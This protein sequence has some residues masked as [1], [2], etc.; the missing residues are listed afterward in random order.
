MATERRIIRC[1]VCKARIALRI[2][3]GH[4]ERHPILL[5]CPKC[6]I[7]IPGE[8]EID[9]EAIAFRFRFT[10]G[11]DVVGE[12]IDNAEYYAEVSGEL[13]TEKLRTLPDGKV[14]PFFSPMFKAMA[15]MGDESFERY[16]HLVVGFIHQSREYWPQIKRTNELWN[17]GQHEHCKNELRSLGL[18]EDRYPL[19]NDLEMLKAMKHLNVNFI[20]AILPEGF[21]S[22]D[23]DA[24]SGTIL[25]LCDTQKE[26]LRA[27]ARRLKDN[28]KLRRCRE[29]FVSR[30]DHFIQTFPH[31]VPVFSAAYYKAPEAQVLQEKGLFTG[32]LRT[33]SQY[34]I[35]S[36]ENLIEMADGIVA[37][38]NLIHRNDYN[39]MRPLRKD[40]VALDDYARLQ[41][42]DRLQFIINADE[43]FGDCLGPYINNRVR[44]S[45][46]HGSTRF[47]PITQQLD[48]YS[49]LAQTTPAVSKYLTEFANDCRL[50][51]QGL[52]RLMEVNTWLERISLFDEGQHPSPLRGW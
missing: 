30:V 23:A 22:H 28:G 51:L 44:N 38:N 50:T 8:I 41:K 1:T 15:E 2:L 49:G 52:F 17:N 39:A 25:G 26:Q 40:V 32:S 21:F 35:D 45:I 29:L 10:N 14:P 11:E 9:Q 20:G 46:G 48:F 33:L 3:I 5:V 4:L 47:D 16:S 18:P 13:L 12:D 27:L 7:D 42:G 36:Y 43:D 37:L 24:I 6:R 19:S 34:Y 31:L